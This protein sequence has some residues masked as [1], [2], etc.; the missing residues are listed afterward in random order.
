MEPIEATELAADE[1]DA[2]FGAL[3]DATRRDI[4]VRAIDG[5][6]GV[7]ELAEPYDMSFA[8]VQKHVAVLERSG[9]VTKRTDGRRRVVTTDID[10]L[11]GARALLDRYELLWRHRFHS[12]REILDED[13]ANAHH[14]RDRP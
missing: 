14:E 9:L 3:A 13:D 12:M 1:V 2:L 4:L 6:L 11:R 7:S 10:G 8:A 5:D